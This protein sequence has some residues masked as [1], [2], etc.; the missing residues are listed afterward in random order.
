V[1]LLAVGK[2]LDAATKAAD[3]LAERGVDSEV[4]DV[5]SCAP[6]D[7]EMIV[8]AARH[9]LVV[10]IEDGVRDGGVGS[11]IAD[12][13]RAERCD[14]KVVVLGLPTRFIP[15]GEAHHIIAQLGLDAEGIE[16]TVREQ[17]G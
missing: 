15:H 12:R 4:W 5:R 2:M 7:D 13:V 9:E 3:R 1:C 8:A 10:T 14:A 17:L 6:L 11:A 16:R